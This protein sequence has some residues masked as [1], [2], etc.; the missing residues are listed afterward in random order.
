MADVG[1]P[2]I[3]LFALLLVDAA[4]RYVMA[5]DRVTGWWISLAVC[6]C[7][8]AAALLGGLEP[9][10][11][12]ALPWAIAAALNLRTSR[13]VRARLEGVDGAPRA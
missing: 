9:A 2:L 10:A 12:L 13:R 6:P 4:A 7:W 3:T 8:A 5:R 11:F 1:M